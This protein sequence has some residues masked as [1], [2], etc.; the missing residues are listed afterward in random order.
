MRIEYSFL[1]INMEKADRDQYEQN[2][3]IECIE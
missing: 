3:N 1:D 2:S